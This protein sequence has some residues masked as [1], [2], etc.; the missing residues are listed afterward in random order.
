MSVAKPRTKDPVPRIY[1]GGEAVEPVEVLLRW[2]GKRSAKWPETLF[3]LPFTFAPGT[4]NRA[5]LGLP[6][7][8]EEARVHRLDDSALG[9]SLADRLRRGA[10][11]DAGTARYA[12]WLSVRMGSLLG[13]AGSDGT[14][15]ASVFEVHERIGADVA[16]R[17]LRAQADR[18][19]DGLAVRL[20]GRAHCARGSR[21]CKK[22]E[23]AAAEPATAALLDL[24]PDN[25]EAARPTVGVVRGGVKTWV[26][27]DVLRRFAS[28]EEAASFAE[29]HGIEDVGLGVAEP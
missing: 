23:A 28:V 19:P 11:K 14:P 6:A 13:G 17:D 29:R 8:G 2:I 16:A 10:A 7:A 22:C 27:Y 18:A 1:V 4:T 21:R 24:C 25:E 12:I 3:K 9:I 15:V 20:L 26:A 5:A